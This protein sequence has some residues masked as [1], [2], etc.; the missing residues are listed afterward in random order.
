[1]IPATPLPKL[2]TTL[3]F[4]SVANCATIFST[5]SDISWYSL[6]NSSFPTRTVSIWQTVHFAVAP[7][8]MMLL[9]SLALWGSIPSALLAVIMACANG[10]SENI[11][12][13][14]VQA[15]NSWRLVPINGKISDTT[16]VP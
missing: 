7:F 4:P 16:G 14:A 15:S 11:S 5:S 1:M 10:C 2:T 9:K 3:V 8:P 6:M 12:A 13:P